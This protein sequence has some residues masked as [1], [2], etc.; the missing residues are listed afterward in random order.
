[1]STD[2]VGNVSQNTLDEKKELMDRL[3]YA[4]AELANMR[5]VFDM[6]ITRAKSAAV[7]NVVRKFITFYEDFERVVKNVENEDVSPTLKEALKMLLKEL[8]NLLASEGVERMDV[9]GKEFNPFD[10]EA[11]EFYESD[12][13]KSETIVE[14]VSHG[15]RYRDKVLKPPRVKVARPK[16]P[17]I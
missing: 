16:K 5:R 7:E 8:E 15:Y 17:V 11:V 14:I 10:H 6:E 3:S 2:D 13:V 12:E 9:V 4:M 1:M